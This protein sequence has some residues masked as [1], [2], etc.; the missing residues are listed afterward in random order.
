M[1]FALFLVGT[2]PRSTWSLFAAAACGEIPSQS[3]KDETGWAEIITMESLTGREI[4]F[5]S[6]VIQ[7]ELQ[8]EYELVEVRQRTRPTIWE[9]DAYIDG[10]DSDC[11]FYE[12]IQGF[13][14][15]LCSFGV[16]RESGRLKRKRLLGNRSLPIRHS[17]DLL[18]TA[19][20]V[21]LRGLRTKKPVANPFS[22]L[23]LCQNEEERCWCL[24][25]YIWTPETRGLS[26]LCQFGN[27]NDWQ[28]KDESTVS[29]HLFSLIL[30]RKGVAMD[31][32]TIKDS[33]W[34][35]GRL[36]EVYFGCH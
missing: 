7:N 11:M 13:F 2:V 15:D 30:I 29:K 3:Q 9:I 34:Y 31:S 23:L 32:L 8:L 33:Y 10:E 26:S 28:N 20:A 18:K 21:L 27:H 14:S 36:L 6:L 5:P 17:F 25:K 1:I 19:G 24:W 16:S 22:D 4:V 35:F 12:P